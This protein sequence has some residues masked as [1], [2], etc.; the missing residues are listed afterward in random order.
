MHWIQERT[1]YSRKSARLL[2]SG[3]ETVAAIALDLRPRRLAAEGEY[4]L[5][6][7]EGRTYGV[8]V[9]FKAMVAV[10][11][12]IQTGQVINRVRVK[13]CSLGVILPGEQA[14]RGCCTAWQFAD[15]FGW[16]NMP[17]HLNATLGEAYS[18]EHETTEVRNDRI[19]DG[20]AERIWISDQFL[21]KFVARTQYECISYMAGGLLSKNLAFSLRR[22]RLPANPQ[23]FDA[24]LALHVTAD[25]SQL[26][27]R[28]QCRG[29]ALS[30]L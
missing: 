18:R 16:Q 1:K 23:R 13:R 22:M 17:P 15:N 20:L 29:Q 7:S 5:H 24:S 12:G 21:I 3:S 2:S 6:H 25:S 14:P 30:Q 27:H 11:E 28:R 8:I 9:K 19:H 4:V 10:E 26:D